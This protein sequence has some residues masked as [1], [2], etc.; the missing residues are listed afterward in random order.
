[1]ILQPGAWVVIA[2]VF[3][4]GVRAKGI[5]IGASSNWLNNFAVCSFPPLPRLLIQNINLS[6]KIHRLAKQHL[7]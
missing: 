2:E 1:M 6:N 7:P 4:L 5:S 3:P